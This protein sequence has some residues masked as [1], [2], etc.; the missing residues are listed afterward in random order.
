MRL[1]GEGAEIEHESMIEKKGNKTLT[2]HNFHYINFTHNTT[3]HTQSSSPFRTLSKSSLRAAVS[4]DRC[5]GSE[6]C[7][8]SGAV[9]TCI[10]PHSPAKVGSRLRSH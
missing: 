1:G 9:R 10:H 8:V 7:I 3:R 5:R 2:S 4:Q 6:L